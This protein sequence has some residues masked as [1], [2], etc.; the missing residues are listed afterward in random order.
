VYSQ[1]LVSPTL[2]NYS[3]MDTTQLGKC[4]EDGCFL[5]ASPSCPS[6]PNHLLPSL[7]IIGTQF[8]LQG[9]KHTQVQHIRFWGV[10]TLWV[11]VLSIATVPDTRKLALEGAER[12]RCCVVLLNY[13][14]IPPKF[15]LDFPRSPISIAAHPGT[16]PERVILLPPANLTYPNALTS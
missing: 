1:K 4:I 2:A 15:L 10:C 3:L 16:T 7:G 13:N 9:I 11:G 12:V 5:K 6:C 8:P 14:P